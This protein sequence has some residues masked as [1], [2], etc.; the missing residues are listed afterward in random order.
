MSP[1][2]GPSDVFTSLNPAPLSECAN[3]GMVHKGCAGKWSE[4]MEAGLWEGTLTG[5]GECSLS[6]VG[7][8][9][10][11]ACRVSHKTPEPMKEGNLG[12]WFGILKRSHNLV[13]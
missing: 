7:G 12:A 2:F 6:C 10:A 8:F 5:L 3:A 9:R 13:F 4:K 1:I 11:F